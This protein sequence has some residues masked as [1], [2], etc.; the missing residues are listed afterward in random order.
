MQK[1]PY[2]NIIVVVK[3][4]GQDFEQEKKMMDVVEYYLKER[5]LDD[6]YHWDE[7]MGGVRVA[8]DVNLDL[9]MGEFVGI[10][11]VRRTEY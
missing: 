4:I 8:D 2:L 9:D 7:I 3:G 1:E 11:R 5:G 10:V 6:Y